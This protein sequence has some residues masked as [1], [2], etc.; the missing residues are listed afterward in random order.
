MKTLYT[1]LYNQ[2]KDKPEV[3]GLCH[4]I[5]RLPV[6]LEERHEL[7]KHFKS[8]R[9]YS[10]LFGLFSKHR[11][12]AKHSTYSYSNAYWWKGRGSYE[13]RKQFVLHLIKTLK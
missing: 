2:I 3:Y 9:P 4:E 12:F 10:Y 6:T 8:N 7:E 5:R 11:E 13:Q 1:L